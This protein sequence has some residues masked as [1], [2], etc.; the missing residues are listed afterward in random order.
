M[1]LRSNKDIYGQSS[2]PGKVNEYLDPSIN[3]E[4]AGT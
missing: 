1:N 2:N 4:T 3:A